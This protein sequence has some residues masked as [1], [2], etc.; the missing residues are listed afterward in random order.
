MCVFRLSASLQMNH[1]IL[2][3]TTSSLHDQ[4]IT[5]KQDIINKCDIISLGGYCAGRWRSG[6]YR[7]LEPAASGF[8]FRLCCVCCLHALPVLQYMQ[9]RCCQILHSVCM[10]ALGWTG[11][12]SKV[13]IALHKVV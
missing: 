2:H 6:Y 12:L 13:Y 1:Y 7:R 3:V 4:T 9:I 10:C 11:T 5:H 8:D